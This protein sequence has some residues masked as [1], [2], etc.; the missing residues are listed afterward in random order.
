MKLLFIISEIV[1]LIIAIL[2]IAVG[3][4]KKRHALWITGRSL[5]LA[6]F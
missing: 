2:F 6:G 5:V 3:I 1:L 4:K